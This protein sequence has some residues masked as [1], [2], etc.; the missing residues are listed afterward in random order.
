MHVYNSLFDKYI[1]YSFV[2]IVDIRSPVII[3]HI[4]Y[5]NM[6]INFRKTFNSFDNIFNVM[7]LYSVL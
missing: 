6:T 7:M 5:N 2:M 1:I 4:C 3:L